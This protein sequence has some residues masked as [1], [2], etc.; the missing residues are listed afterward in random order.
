MRCGGYP[1]FLANWL[2]TEEVMRSKKSRIITESVQA[3]S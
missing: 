2:L 1:G 3:A